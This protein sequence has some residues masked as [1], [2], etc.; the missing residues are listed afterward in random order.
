MIDQKKTGMSAFLNNLQK[1][2]DEEES[3]RQMKNNPQYKLNVIADEKKKGLENCAAGVIC[4]IYRDALPMDPEYKAGY[5]S[6]LDAGFIQHIK[7]KN[8]EGVYAYIVDSAKAGSK[9]AKL[10]LEAV[11]SAINECCKKFYENLD[12]LDADKI[13]LGPESK[14]VKDGIAQITSKM[15]YEEIS[16]II[17]DNVQETVRREIE[18]TKEEDRKL[19]ELQE[20][21][22]ADET[23][24][25]ESAIDM[26]LA[27]AGMS[28]KQ[29]QP[30]LFGGIMIGNVTMFSESGELDEEHVQKKAFFESVKEYTKLETLS[31]LDMQRYGVGDVENLALKYAYGK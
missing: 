28:T 15:D 25:T 17:E 14:E 1:L 26:A 7:G 2:Q 11:N 30:S 10:M 22:A 23:V 19:A 4:K 29:F 6:E 27:Q 8:P 12:E 3:M 16:K 18:N 13:D 31:V 24:Q 9:P 21:L 20:K 5:M